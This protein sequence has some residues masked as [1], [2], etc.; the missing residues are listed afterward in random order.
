MTH[1]ILKL[2]IVLSDVQ[3]G[4]LCIVECFDFGYAQWVP[5]KLEVVHVFVHSESLRFVLFDVLCILLHV[6][7]AHRLVRLRL[8]LLLSCRIL[9]ILLIKQQVVASRT[10]SRFPSALGGWRRK[11]HLI[12]GIKT[13]IWI[14]TVCV[15]LSR[16]TIHLSPAILVRISHESLLLGL[17]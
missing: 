14:E 17:V 16:S 15:A 10:Y 11:H 6:E 9:H 5:L 12:G 7:L 8:L 2:H 1:E 13:A 4:T 3:I